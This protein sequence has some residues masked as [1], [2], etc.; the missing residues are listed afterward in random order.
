MRILVLTNMYPPHAYGGY[1]QCC[2]DVVERWRA[3][4]HEVLVLTST[5]RV[6]GVD[7]GAEPPNEVRRLL[8]LYWADHEILDPPLA[9]ALP[10]GALE[11]EGPRRCGR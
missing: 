1:E 4:G 8:R 6:P 10:D 11:P 2:R 3:A 5:V 7:E 9:R